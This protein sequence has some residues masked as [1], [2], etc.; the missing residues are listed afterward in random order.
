MSF[1]PCNSPHKHQMCQYAIEHIKGKRFHKDIRWLQDAFEKYCKALRADDCDSRHIVVANFIINCIYALD[2]EQ[3]MRFDIV[4]EGFA[5]VFGRGYSNSII[6]DT[7]CD[8]PPP[9]I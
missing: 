5:R 1:Q 4:L 8:K 2:H 6:I 9:L 3:L 7:I